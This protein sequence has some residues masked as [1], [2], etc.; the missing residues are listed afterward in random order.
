MSQ[1]I[2]LTLEV[3][4]G[5]SSSIDFTIANEWQLFCANYNEKED[6]VSTL[7]QAVCTQNVTSMSDFV[8]KSSLQ[9]I[10]IKF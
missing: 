6:N 2:L 8:S 5:V 4:Q 3:L 1:D 10:C 9:V 7:T